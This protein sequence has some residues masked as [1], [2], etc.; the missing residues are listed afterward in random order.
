MIRNSLPFNKLYSNF[1]HSLQLIL[2][3]MQEDCFDVS[4]LL[5]YYILIEHIVLMDEFMC[6][7]QFCRMQKIYILQ[8]QSKEIRQ[9]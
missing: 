3:L 8:W 6:Q 4:F 5:H 2:T 1:V 9:T 7:F